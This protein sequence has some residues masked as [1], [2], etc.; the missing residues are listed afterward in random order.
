MFHNI[1]QPTRDRMAYLEAIDTRDRLDGTPQMQ[2]LRQIPPVTGR[3]LALLA[4][5]APPGR[6]LEIGASAGY[7]ALWISLALRERGG[8]L[9]TFE[10]LADKVRYAQETFQAAGIEALVQIIPGDVRTQLAPYCE[11]VA[12]CFLD[13]EKDLYSFCYEQIVAGLV[14]GGFLVVDNVISHAQ[15]LVEF[16]E[17]AE[18]DPRMDALTLPVGQ[19]VLICR[20]VNE[21]LDESDNLR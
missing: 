14:P 8:Q 15:V 13:T 12:F 7:S 5:T 1:P 17:R 21:L 19:G 18:S 2:R 6:F 3:L 20:K 9:V 16:L 4:A 10:L 11:N